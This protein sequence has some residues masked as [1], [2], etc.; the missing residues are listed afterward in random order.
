MAGGKKS[1]V[2]PEEAQRILAMYRK[3]GGNITSTSI[4]SGR[5]TKTVK[6]AVAAALK[7][8][9]PRRRPGHAAPSRG[10]A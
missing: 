9:Q 3:H 8:E 1:Y 5:T 2:T 4:E 6:C 10:L 7:S